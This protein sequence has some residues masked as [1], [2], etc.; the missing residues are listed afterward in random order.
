MSTLI[1][2]IIKVGK[3]GKHPEA[4]TLGIT[5][6]Y[7]FPVIFKLGEFQEGDKAIYFPVDA[8]L[9]I[10]PEFAFIWQNRENPSERQRTIKAKK[11]RGIFSMGIIMP[12]KL[13]GLE[14]KEVGTNVAEILGVVKSPDPVEPCNM[15]GKNRKS[16]AWFS[17]YTDIESARKYIKEFTL[18][19][20]VIFTE[21]IHGCLKSNQR[22]RMADG[23][24]KPIN[25][26]KIG[27]YVLGQDN[28]RNIIPSK[29]LNTFNNGKCN[30]WLEIKTKR[31]G[32]GKGNS[33]SKVVAT[34]NHKFYCPN[35]DSYKE[36]K[37]L[38]VNDKVSG[39][40]NDLSLTP[41]QLEYKRITIEQ[42]IIS[43]TDVT[44][45]IKSS[46]YDIETETNNFF[47]PDI[48]VHNSNARFSYVDNDLW[49]G[50]HRLAKA[51]D[52]DN[53]WS[54]WA[55]ENN[56]GEKL[57]NYPNLLFFGEL[58][59]KTQAGNKYHYG[60]PNLCK[61]AF[62][63]IFDITKGK[64]LNYDDAKFIFDKLEFNSVPIIYR[65]PLISFEQV[66]QLA[67]GPTIIG[68]GCHNREGI[69]IKPSVERCSERLGRMIVKLHGKE[70]LL[71]DYAK[72]M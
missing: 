47:C 27:E 35:I 46:K 39:I 65:G 43:I 50:S 29:V 59:G 64:Y 21:K 2:E 38:N 5:H 22:I 19:E 25:K 28:N 72:K 18:G 61:V 51:N 3:W 10:K 57:A 1:V 14:D 32:L 66:E 16:P 36:L 31:R 48:L 24:S 20:E 7:Q 53:E 8:M 45:K 71:S 69:V 70:F 6:V 49:V 63:D 56:I 41:I 23:T 67:D 40:R 42:E 62:F 9:P 34:P 37:D 15:S 54:K 30:K 55:R 44:Y 52:D 58:Y 26:I 12:V 60:H 68:N 17:L 33:F 13:F 4:D 11:L